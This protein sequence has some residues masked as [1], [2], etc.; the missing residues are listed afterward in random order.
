[1][2]ENQFAKLKALLQRVQKNSTFYQEKFKKA[3]FQAEH[4]QKPADMGQIPFTTKEELREAYPLNIQAVPDEDVVRIHSSSGTTGKP[5]I[6][7]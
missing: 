7:P 4:V 3:G 6:I 5:I 1:M 2:N